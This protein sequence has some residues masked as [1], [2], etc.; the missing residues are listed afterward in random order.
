MERLL[1]ARELAE[2]L[3]RPLATIYSWSYRGEGPPGIKTGREL[4]YRESDVE[5]WLTRQD[6]VGSSS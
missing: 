2:Y 1:S 5:R 4:R 6:K 3:G